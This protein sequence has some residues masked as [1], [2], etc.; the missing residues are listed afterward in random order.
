M[1]PLQLQY[2]ISLSD[3]RKAN[4]YATAF[5]HRKAVAVMAVVL[6]GAALYAIGAAAGLGTPNALVF[7]LAGAYLIWGILLFAE[8]E[9]RIRRYLR[10]GDDLLGLDYHAALTEKTISFRVPERK[11]AVSYPLKALS[12]VFELSSLFLIYSSP[13]E[14]YILPKSV[15][16]PEEL[17]AVRQNFRTQLRDLFSS[18]F[19][20]K[21]R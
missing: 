7:F 2:K 3:F 8:T 1:F 20:K 5:R 16:S 21:S 17:S 13:K 10:S 18:R 15:L 9:R 14:V 6:I 19:D 12:C 4:Y 11:I